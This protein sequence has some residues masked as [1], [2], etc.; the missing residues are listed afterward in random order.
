[1]LKKVDISK[2]RKYFQS[3]R[4]LIPEY[5]WCYH[6]DLKEWQ[7]FSAMLMFNIAISEKSKK[8]M[9]YGPRNNFPDTL[10]PELA[11]VFFQKILYFDTY[12]S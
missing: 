8:N 6:N 12:I 2:F 1:M 11:R 9:T 4:K 10:I 3:A 7:F 5:F